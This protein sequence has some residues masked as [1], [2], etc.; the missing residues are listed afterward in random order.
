MIHGHSRNST[1]RGK[2]TGA[3]GVRPLLALSACVSMSA[4]AS[5]SSTGPPDPDP[6][7]SWSSSVSL[8]SVHGRV[9]V[10][11]RVH[12]VGH[13]GSMLVHRSSQDDGA[14]WSSPADIA[15]AS[16]NYPMQYGG[17]FAIGDTVYLLTAVDDMGPS[18]QHLDF[19]KSTNN[20]ATWTAPV[21][22]TG[23]GQQLR[24]ANIVARGSTVHV[25]GGQSGSGG[26]GTGLF[27]F[28]STDGG[29]TWGTGVP[30]YGEADGSARM[31]VDGTTVHV[32][33]GVKPT[34]TS[35][36]G[37]T[38][39]MRSVDDGATWG[40]AVPV[41]DNAF[42][43]R[44]QVAAASGRVIMMWQRESSTPGGP[45]P[46]DRLGYAVSNDG[47][48]TWS[49]TRLLPDDTGVDRQHH[50]VWMTPGGDVHVAWSHGD[51][52]GSS[53]PTGYKYSPD[54]GTT[55][56]PTEFA[57]STGGSANLPHGIVADLDW[58]HIITQPGAGI[59][60]RRPIP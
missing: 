44:Q 42:E 35:F 15:S 43:S 11:N 20:G 49:S 28:R 48:A 41:G 3:L 31:A 21:R 14:T 25:F 24:R 52:T 53:T 47:G 56:G 39:Y 59:Y 29:A 17:L 60:A 8:V 30:L 10:G 45:L 38:H 2:L 57:V 58:V 13:Q 50:L 32:A 54:Y 36:G 19:R 40:P 37:R 4:C 34:S 16:G 9:A 6:T 51:P 33:F 18:S 26:Y 23:T 7:T 27:Y 5:G 22:V 55:W 1:V 46:A 12:V